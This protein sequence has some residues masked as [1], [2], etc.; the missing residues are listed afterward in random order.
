MTSSA[1]RVGL[2]LPLF[3]GDP[4]K[5]LA[6]ARSAEELGYDGVFA[7]DHFFPPGAPAD[8]ASVEVYTTLASV[9]ATTA[10]VTLGTLVT[11][12]VLRPPG[13]V[14]KMVS[15]IDMVAG[16]GRMLVGVG[17]GDPIDEG[18]HRA[19]G[20]PMQSVG[21]RRAYL[22][23]WVVAVRTILEGGPF[24]GSERLAAVPGP[25]LPAPSVAPPVWVGGLADDVV[26]IAARSADGW[27]GWGVAPDVFA[28]KAELLREEAARSGRSQ[29]PAATWAGI[30]LVGE[31]EKEAAALA[32]KR[33]GKGVDALAWAGPA[34]EFPSFLEDLA[35]A[36]ATWT[37]LVLTGP[38]DRKDLV[39]E[40]VLPDLTRPS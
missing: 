2:I 26:R 16:P 4:A 23:E 21:E 30:V 28:A 37:I 35:A 5:I 19:F 7:F 22:E 29:L 33:Q 10:R 3:S 38:Q 40:R 14:A 12:A 15:T 20:F 1:P 11:R 31:D 9:A 25:L 18:E 13:L 36:G 27:N 8:R 32:E 39:A 17:S 24:A 34:E 6:T